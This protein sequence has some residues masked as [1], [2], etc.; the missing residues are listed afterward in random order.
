MRVMQF[1][2]ECP[3]PPISGADIR[4]T[5][6]WNL[7]GVSAYRCV[8]LTQPRQAGSSPAVDYH[9]LTSVPGSN[10]W[11][12]YDPQ[13]P[14]CLRFQETTI[15]EVDRLLAG[16]R[17]TVA[18]LEGVAWRDIVRH[19][20]YRGLPTVLDMHNVESSLYEERFQSQPWH[21]RLLAHLSRRRPFA[22]VR[23]ADRELSLLADQTWVCSDDDKSILRAWGGKSHHTIPNPIPDESLL[24]APLSED[25][26]RNPVPLFIGHLAYFPNVAAVL[27][28]AHHLPRELAVRGNRIQPIVAGRS[29]SRAIRRLASEG[30]IQLLTN[31]VSCAEL[32]ANSGYTLLPIRLG[33]GTRLKAIE[34]LAAG[35][36]MIATKKAVEGLGLLDGIHYCR[37][38]TMA[39]MS[40]RLCELL[41][42]PRQALAI[43]E[44]GRHFAAMNFRRSVVQEAISDALHAFDLPPLN[45]TTSRERNWEWS[46]PREATNA[47]RKEGT[48]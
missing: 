25:R 31:P 9:R 5:L 11:R 21:R 30:A 44:R 41:E 39:A 14:T 17:P 33:S 8:G 43:A 40:R 22:A 13:Q 10:P 12:N 18:V 24:A 27:E 29:P 38:E 26:Y 32:L 2:V 48:G 28:I 45:S 47:T 23:E 34:A 46:K 15:R 4:N 37:A 20:Q 42:Q 36:V 3:W 19:L 7:P 16:F 35:V 1:I 6:L